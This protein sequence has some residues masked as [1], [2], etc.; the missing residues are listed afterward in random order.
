MG[1]IANTITQLQNKFKSTKYNLPFLDANPIS[2]K[3]FMET[4]EILFTVQFNSDVIS[5]KCLI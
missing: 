2:A 4:N 3:N 1:G 5:G